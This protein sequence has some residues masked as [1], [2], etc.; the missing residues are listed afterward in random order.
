MVVLLLVVL[1]VGVLTPR[2]VRHFR[3][4]TAKS[5]IEDFHQQLHLLERA[6]PKLVE[7]AYR[8]AS[9]D[10]VGFGEPAMLSA[11]G[12][13]ETG[14]G[15]G[16][17]LMASPA[18]P[19]SG[20]ARHHA[21]AA[22]RRARRR[23]RDILLGA[24]TITV[25][26]GLLGAMHALHLLWVLTAIS[27]LVVAG[28]VALAAYVQILDAERQALRPVADVGGRQESFQ[29]AWTRRQPRDATR[30]VMP[31]VEVVASEL[32]EARA[33]YPGSWDGIGLTST[34]HLELAGSPR[35]AAPV[36]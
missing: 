18:H 11:T 13:V 34:R 25:V 3:Q 17:V 2:A 6:G 14:S 23:R 21:S 7:P 31:G 24:L 19:Q 20:V 16:L 28:Y 26:T 15:A 33:G 29:P 32:R 5:S 30:P 27:V 36:R 1:W 35:H 10:G 12:W 9:G 8:L 22:A 4:A